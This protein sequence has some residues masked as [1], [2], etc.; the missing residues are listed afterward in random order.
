M[1]VSTDLSVAGLP[2]ARQIDDLLD[3]AG[4]TK[5]AR[6]RCDLLIAFSYAR[7][8]YASVQQAQKRPSPELLDQL[9]TSILKTR[10]LVERLEKDAYTS[11]IGWEVHRLETGVVKAI[12]FAVLGKHRESQTVP[13][14]TFVAINMQNLLRAWHDKV[15][16]VP[17]RKRGQPVR[18]AEEAIVFYAAEFFRR[19]SARKPSNDVKIHFA[20]LPGDFVKQ[21]PELNR[22]IWTG[23]FGRS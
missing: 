12:S 16:K 18:Q 10:R 11:D 4:V 20:L 22:A 8:A 2:D 7:S 17:R 21:S 9:Q 13:D 5:N 19:H 3:V 6:T 15:T 1:A 23:K 14:T